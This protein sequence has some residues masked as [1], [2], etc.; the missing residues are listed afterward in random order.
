MI[1]D[2]NYDL[3]NLKYLCMLHGMVIPK[4][5]YDT[6]TKHYHITTSLETF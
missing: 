1:G 3:D 4:Q 6:M 5:I 2:S